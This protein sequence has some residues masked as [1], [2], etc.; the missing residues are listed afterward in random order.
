L[1]R[2][3]KPT[4]VRAA[5]PIARPSV[6]V[7]PE[8]FAG[9]AELGAVAETA[10]GVDEAAACTPA[11]AGGGETEPPSNEAWEAST[12]GAAVPGA[13]VVPGT[14]VEGVAATTTVGPVDV[15]VFAGVGAAPPPNAAP[16]CDPGRKLGIE[17]ATS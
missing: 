15:G 12:E 2:R 17:L 13:G 9:V 5:A 4:T 7:R 14:T 3:T 11:G 1:R 10:V 8:A 6:I 16:A